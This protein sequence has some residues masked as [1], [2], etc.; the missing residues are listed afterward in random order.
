[1]R[2]VKAIEDGVACISVHS[3]AVTSSRLPALIVEAGVEGLS[4]ASRPRV[5]SRRNGVRRAEEIPESFLAL[6]FVR[7]QHLRI[8]WLHRL[9]HIFVPLGLEELLLCFVGIGLLR[10][11]IG[12]HRGRVANCSWSL[13]QGTER[14]AVII[15]GFLHGSFSLISVMLGSLRRCLILQLNLKHFIDGPKSFIKTILLYVPIL[16][17]N[18][19]VFFRGRPPTRRYF[20]SCIRSAF[21][22]LHVHST[23]TLFGWSA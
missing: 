3:F 1:M 9:H 22:R 12:L 18:R 21:Q 20:D 11:R 6:L 5:P 10:I 2:L 17:C 7:A 13:W 16:S 14:I 23:G 4:A 8:D 15:E 19:T